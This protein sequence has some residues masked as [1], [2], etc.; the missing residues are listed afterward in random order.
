MLVSG[1]THVHVIIE[2][3]LLFL[4]T[5]VYYINTWVKRIGFDQNS[6]LHTWTHYTLLFMYMHSCPFCMIVWTHYYTA[7][8]HVHTCTCTCIHV[9]S[10][11]MDTLLHNC[12][13][14]TCTYTCTCT[15]TM[16]S[17]PFCMYMYAHYTCYVCTCI[18]STCT[19]CNVLLICNFRI[20]HRIRE[21]ENMLSA[22]FSH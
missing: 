6:I 8:I 2:H 9:R 19:W 21:E 12:Y 16:H 17:Y 22:S 10:A 5:V 14:C 11:C 13:S 3:L 7:V 18:Y 15:C 20:Q 4:H 1:C